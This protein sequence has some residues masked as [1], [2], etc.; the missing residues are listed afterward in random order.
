M[1]AAQAK[2]ALLGL[3]SASL[4]VPVASLT[5]DKG[6][7]SGGGKTVTYGQ[8]IGGK[9]FNVIYTGT[10]LM[11]GQPPAKP[12]RATS[13]SA[14][15]DSRAYDI[16]PI[17]TGAH[18]YVQNVRVPGMLHGRIV[19]P[20]GQG[21]YGDG[22]NP[23]PVA[24]DKSS[25]SHIPNV[26]DRAG[27]QLPR[28]RR[29]E[30]V[31]RDPGGRPAEGDVVDPAGDLPG[32]EPLDGDAG[33]RQRRARRRRAIAAHDRRTSTQAMA[34]AAKTYS[35]TFKYHYQMHAPIGPNAALADVT[36]TGA[37]IYTHVKDGYGT[38]RPKIA[39][40]LGACRRHDAASGSSTTRARARS[41]A[42]PSTSTPASRR[43]S[44]RKAVGKPVRLQ[45][46]R[47]DE[48]GWDNYG[49][50]TLWDVKG[51]VDANGK[52][53]ALGR[54]QLGHGRVLDDADGV[55]DA[56]V[57]GI[58]LPTGSGSG[59]GRHDV[60]GDAVRHPE[61]ADHREDRPGA[62][63]L[64]QDV[65]AAGAERPADLLRQRAGDRPARV[66]GGAWTRT[67]SG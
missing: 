15:L 25:I 66:P 9:L 24:V 59:P 18:T 54:H 32:R 60:L 48:H 47:W 62:E 4:G 43:R 39:A 13:R 67:S 1:A 50:A 7:V 8:L 35:G 41:A 49:P 28:R 10:T 58:A 11:A 40:V 34:S 42:A 64:L 63:Q 31:R 19:R 23:V 36:P 17:V 53:V 51:G 30:G 37:I 12:V 38:S 20:R 45:Y 46:M 14:S 56:S 29:A 22:T 27:G 52:L 55:D 6:V 5:V 65:D 26:T 57:T 61:P 44:C 21:A 16:P 33:V 3:A 2:Q